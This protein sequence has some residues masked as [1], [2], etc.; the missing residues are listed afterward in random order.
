MND[1]LGQILSVFSSIRGSNSDKYKQTSADVSHRFKANV[2]TRS[3]N[4]LQHD[5]HPLS[6]LHLL[7]FD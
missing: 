7:G 1:L 2:Y 3:L 6:V 4:A 5:P